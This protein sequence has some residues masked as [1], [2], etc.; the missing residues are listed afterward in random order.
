[1][2]TILSIAVFQSVISF[3]MLVTNKGKDSFERTMAMMLLLLTAHF[4]T[5]FVFL[6]VLHNEFVFNNLATSFGFAYGPFIYLA[7]RSINKGNTPRWQVLLHM[8]PFFIFSLFYLW[9]TISLEVLLVDNYVKTYQEITNLIEIPY[10]LVYSIACLIQ[11][12]RFKPATEI[13]KTPE[14]ATDNHVRS[15]FWHD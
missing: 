11:L 13:E 14:K 9:T 7:L 3:L 4:T 2:D 10:I 15:A 6:I 5:K 8:G 12:Y 1:M